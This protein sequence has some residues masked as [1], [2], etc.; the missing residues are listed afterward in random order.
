MFLH[1]LQIKL[2]FLLHDDFDIVFLGILRLLHQLILIAEFDGCRI[3]DSRPYIQHMHLLRC[4]VIHVVTHFRPWSY[5]RHVP[6]EHINQLRQLIK[7]KL[8]DKESGIQDIKLVKVWGE[9]KNIVNFQG[10]VSKDEI[11]A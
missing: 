2:D 10:I 9:D 1:I 6:K 4:P 3:S 8:A 5:Q 7:L 11:H